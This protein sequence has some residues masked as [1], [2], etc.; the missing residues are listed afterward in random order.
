MKKVRWGIL[1]AANIAYD[2]LLPALRRSDRAE[3]VAIAR[4]RGTC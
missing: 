4:K 2:Q 1:S 3:I